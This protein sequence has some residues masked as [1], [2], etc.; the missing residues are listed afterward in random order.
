MIISK[1]FFVRNKHQP[2]FISR[3]SRSLL[4]QFK[5]PAARPSLVCIS[6]RTFAKRFDPSVD[7]YARLGKSLSAK[8]S[9]TDIKH[10]FY[11]LA[12]KHHP[13]SH[14]KSEACP[15]KYKLITEAYDILS[16][17]ELKREY[18]AARV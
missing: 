12:K 6:H 3:P 14:S 11:E 7:Y 15:D 9:E 5:L 16:N 2:Q 4:A 17:K 1:V 18:D 13:D 8:S 10:K